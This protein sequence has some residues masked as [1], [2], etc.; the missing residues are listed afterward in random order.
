MLVEPLANFRRP[1]RQPL[2]VERMVAGKS[3]PAMRRATFGD[4]RRAEC[5]GKR[6]QLAHRIALSH[7]AAGEN[8][9]LYPT[10]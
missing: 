8:C 4:H 6:H 10:I 7:A 3:E 1:K 9:S 2:A 5:F